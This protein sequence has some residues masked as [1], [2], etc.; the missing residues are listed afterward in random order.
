MAPHTS[1]NGGRPENIPAY[2]DGRLD[3]ELYMARVNA[4]RSVFEDAF[5]TTRAAFMGSPVQ[6]AYKFA[7][8][9]WDDRDNNRSRQWPELR[10]L[11]DDYRGEWPD[12]VDKNPDIKESYGS[13]E[14]LAWSQYKDRVRARYDLARKDRQLTAAPVDM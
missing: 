9:E 4:A 8:I 12:L 7:D 6:E 1:A 5:D 11:E 10:E 14:D 3:D 2:R 13:P